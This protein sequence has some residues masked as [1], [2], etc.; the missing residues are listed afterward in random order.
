MR[1]LL[2]CFYICRGGDN[3]RYSTNSTKSEAVETTED[4]V[5]KAIPDD[6]PERDYEGYDVTLGTKLARDAETVEM[7][8]QGTTDVASYLVE[9]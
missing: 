7:M 5:H 3:R 8:P 2:L 4:D 6:L 1:D 9:H